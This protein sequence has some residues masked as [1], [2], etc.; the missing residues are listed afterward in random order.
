MGESLK[1]RI[2][3]APGSTTLSWSL[4]TQMTRVATMILMTTMTMMVTM[5]TMAMMVTLA[6]NAPSR[7]G[8]TPAKKIQLAEDSRMPP[9]IIITGRSRTP[10]ENG[11]VTQ[12]SSLLESLEAKVSAALTVSSSGSKLKTDTEI[13]QGTKLMIIDYNT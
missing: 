8:G 9:A 6:L 10:G 11:G 5:V 4:A 13:H 2:I 1:R 3:A 12:A 7:S